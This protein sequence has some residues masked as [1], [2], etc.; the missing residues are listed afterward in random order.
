M[1]TITKVNRRRL[2]RVKRKG[3]SFVAG[4]FLGGIVPALTYH[5][6][7][8]QVESKPMLWLAVAGGLAYSAPMV[9]SW[10]TRYA[11]TVK[12]WGFVVSLETAL[13]V[14]DNITAIPA[15]LALIGLNAWVLGNRINN[16]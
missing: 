8:Y 6:A 4:T 10:F 14:T 13:T 1:Q 15:L 3:W 12:A 16:D 2:N 11:G 9:A 7:H 5:V